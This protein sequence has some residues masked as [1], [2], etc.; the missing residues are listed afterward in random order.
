[1]QTTGA[2]NL[3]QWGAYMQQGMVHGNQSD[4][5]LH[6]VSLDRHWAPLP[7]NIMR[8]VP[9]WQVIKPSTLDRKHLTQSLKQAPKKVQ[10]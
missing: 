3:C 4:A 2:S 7:V 1:M 10:P 9:Y 6:P 8:H 5:H